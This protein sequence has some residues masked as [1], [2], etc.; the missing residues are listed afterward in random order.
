MSLPN[1]KARLK[2]NAKL[3]L[4]DILVFQDNIWEASLIYK[5][6]EKTI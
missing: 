1:L 4:A 2:A 5:Q 6:I 3:N